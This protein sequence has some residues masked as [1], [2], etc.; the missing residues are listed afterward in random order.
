MTVKID[1]EVAI[2]MDPRST[3][4]TTLR[5]LSNADSQ[6]TSYAVNKTGITISIF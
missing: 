4:D 3:P 5:D 1:L 6:K 2:E